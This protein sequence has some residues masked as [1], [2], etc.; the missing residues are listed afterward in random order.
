[1]KH[2]ENLINLLNRASEEYYNTG[3]SFLTDR[4]FDRLYDEL[5]DVEARTGI[6]LP[7]SPTQK[8]GAGVLSE[9]PKVKIEP[10]PMLSLKKVH[11]QDEL[12]E[13]AG[14]YEMVRSIK[15][16]G[17]SVRLIYKDGT[18]FSANSRGNGVIGGL[19]TE[20]LKRFINV[21][22]KIAALGTFIID[23]EAIIK[24]KDFEVVAQ[25]EDLKNPRNAASG[26]LNTLDLN[27]VKKRRLSF[28]AW[29]VIQGG[30]TNS[31]SENLKYAKELG[32]ET[33]YFSKTDS[34]E[35]ILQ[36]ARELSIPCDGVV[37]KFDDLVHGKIQGRTEKAFNNA[38]AW[39]PETDAY[40]TFLLDIT[41][42]VGR[43]GQLTPVANFEP[44]EIDG[45]TV[46]KAS[47]F[48]ETVLKEK[49]GRPWM[50]QP[51][52]VTKQNQV[53]PF[54]VRADTDTKP[55]EETSYIQPLRNC[56]ICG[57]AAI[58][59]TE[60]D[61]EVLFCGN[62]SCSG[63]L[64][65]KITHFAGKTGLDIQRLSERTV[66][67]LIFWGWVNN[68]LDLYNL[69]KYRAEWIKKPGFG[70]KS[71][72]NI[73]MAIEDSKKCELSKFICGLGI[74]LIGVSGAK[75]LAANFD[76]WTDFR[77][78][79]KENFNFCSLSDF[80]DK[81]QEALLNFNYAEADKITELLEFK[82]AEQ[83]DQEKK[84]NG[85]KFVV[86]GRLNRFKNRV[87]LTQT[88]EE[89]GGK[90]VDSVS[91]QTNYLI[92]NDLES[93][94]SKNRQAKNLGIP[95]ISEEDFIQLTK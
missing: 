63:K 70:A 59:R 7:N 53:T 12:D 28:I 9:I 44:I 23:G 84:L 81:A 88:I 15:C 55:S 54:V 73:L 78:A 67:K 77:T 16:D 22:L 68:I 40:E 17:L 95:I 4:E 74:P 33:V 6:H 2:I 92:N 38:V 62:S 31:F 57:Q 36:K 34:N 80:G 71:V 19:I 75:R 86:T 43:S 51:L 85:L 52:W 24:Y 11:T 27:I 60:T 64:I 46:T 1:M 93:N 82:A 87:A 83:P 65:N 72:D 50:G 30:P 49:L 89:L 8:V 90:V 18:L 41:Y 10:I 56:P 5:V 21:P 48:N 69:Q 26:S 76:S 35:Q 45:S 25:T 37:W 58:I 29:D 47:L 3:S 61:R 14:L 39:K 13:F 20:H 79:V 66:E 94:S 91:Q 32:F 42:D